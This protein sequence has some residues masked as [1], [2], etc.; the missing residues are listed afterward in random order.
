ME[1]VA[2]NTF[3][4]P[5]AV[6]FSDFW[7][8]YPRR[9]A[10][11]AA[12]QAWDKLKPAQQMQACVALMDWRT[13]WLQRGDVQFIPHAATWLNGERFDDELPADFVRSKAAPASHSAFK[14]DA[15]TAVAPMPDKLRV[16]LAELKRRQG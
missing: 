9:V 12:L 7:L 14:P 5:N 13:I 11:K 6:E 1:L 4:E 15:P 10:R 3:P 8:L 2:S 16:M